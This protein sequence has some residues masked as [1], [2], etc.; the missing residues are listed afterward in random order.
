MVRTLV[1]TVDRDNDLGVKAGI[2]GPVIGRKA[3]LAAALRL[4]LADPEESDTNAILGALHRHDK[5]NEEVVGD[6]EVQ[7][8]LLTG[9][10][11]VGARSDRAIAIQLDE[12]IQEFQPDRAILITDGAD[13]EVA[14]PIITSRVR[15]DHVEKIIVRQ[16]KGIESTYYYVVKA[17]ED[18]RWRARLLVPIA[19]VMIILGLGLI[20]PNGTQLI[21][22]MPLIFGIWVLAKGLGW[23]Q[24][25]DRLLGDMRS[26]ASGSLLTTLLWALALVSLIIGAVTVIQVFYGT[27]LEIEEWAA[28]ILPDSTGFDIGA[29]NNDIAVWV[30]AI[31]NALSWF[32]V[33][34]FSLFLSLGVLRWK[35]GS[36]TGQSVML[37][38][39]GAVAYFVISAINEV[40]LGM[41]GGQDLNL[42]VKS[43][44]DTWS[45][46][47]LAILGRY[48][49]SVMVESLTEDEE[50]SMENQFYGV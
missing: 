40:A 41:L 6:D 36:F 12:V 42:S 32:L 28:A 43:V 24:Q 7:I 50:G 29:V 3:T 16:S 15:V 48:L 4:G 38:A 31:D 44:S 2:R 20:L 33:A 22:A 13:D 49:L 26:A 35:E 46:P 34:F 18:P 14:L 10:V 17:I 30:I 25:L 5:L 27:S 1:L 9:D 11:R 19:A 47:V 21:G 39:T 37:L 45:I 23:E 8:A